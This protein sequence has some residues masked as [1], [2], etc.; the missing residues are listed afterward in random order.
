MFNRNQSPVQNY[1][2]IVRPEFEFRAAY[3]SLQQQVTSN[4]QAIGG[5]ETASTLP[6]TGH[7]TRFLSTG[8]YFLNSG[9]QGGGRSYNPGQGTANRAITTAGQGTA[10]QT[11][12]PLR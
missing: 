1:F 10:S 9:G 5:L 8:R 6:V 7:A 11:S 12:R 4:D 3:Q 2:G